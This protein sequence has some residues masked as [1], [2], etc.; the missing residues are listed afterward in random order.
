[1]K[2]F[3]F[4]PFC[5]L[6]LLF[7]VLSASISSITNVELESSESVISDRSGRS[8]S[9]AALA[10]EL[11]Q[12]AGGS[13]GDDQSNAVAVDSNGDVYVT[14]AF[15]Q[16]STFGGT[17]LTT[18][19][20]DDIFVAK[21]NST[22]HWLWAVQAGGIYDDEG[23]DIAIDS[24]GDVFVTGK[25]Q[26]TAQFGSDSMTAGPQRMMIAS[27]QNLTPGAIGNGAR[28]GIVTTMADAMGL[29]SLWL[30]L[31]MRM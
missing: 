11:A 9:A 3:G 27:S 15:E 30:L 6:M 28:E 19:G 4:A 8:I 1:M 5:A 7:M 31:D 2:W 21:M 29:Q 13:S 14:G 22:G 23:M 16:T 10:W 26:T 25:F 20:N 17:T 24:S 12:K 18:A